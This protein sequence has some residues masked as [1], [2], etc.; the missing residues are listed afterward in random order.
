MFCGRLRNGLITLLGAA[1]APDAD[2][3]K[4]I[5]MALIEIKVGGNAPQH[6][7]QLLRA[8]LEKT[9]LA[10]IDS[11]PGTTPHIAIT[12]P[13]GALHRPIVEVDVA[14]SSRIRTRP[15]SLTPPGR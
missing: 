14:A 1:R 9:T 8:A 15:T 6:T 5:P 7:L 12:H 13:A 10:A 11:L 2:A 3:T 4:D